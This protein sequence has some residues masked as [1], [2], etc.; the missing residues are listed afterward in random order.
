V[1]DAQLL[2]QGQLC[3]GGSRAVEILRSSSRGTWIRRPAGPRAGSAV[4][5]DWHEVQTPADRHQWFAEPAQRPTKADRLVPARYPAEFPFHSIQ[6]RLEGVDQMPVWLRNAIS[7]VK[8]QWPRT[9][10]TPR[11]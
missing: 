5:L 9:L 3:R 8:R 4:A 1:E 7:C 10:R 2:G 6:R 11:S